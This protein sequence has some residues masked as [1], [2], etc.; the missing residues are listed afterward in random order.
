M[1]V[2]RPT[3][4]LI[5]KPYNASRTM[6]RAPLSFDKLLCIYKLLVSNGLAQRAIRWHSKRFPAR[7]GGCV[8]HS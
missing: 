4:M 5:T 6:D 2:A 1:D 3:P 8:P 7:A